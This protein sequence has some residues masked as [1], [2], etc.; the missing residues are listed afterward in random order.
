MDKFF[1]RL[2]SFTVIPP[3]PSPSKEL[4]EEIMLTVLAILTGVTEEI[5][6]G[7]ASKF[8]PRIFLVIYLSLIRKVLEE[9][10]RKKCR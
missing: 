4:N 3:P 7:R 2:R 10:G 6:Q 8:I 1:R 9:V 5:K